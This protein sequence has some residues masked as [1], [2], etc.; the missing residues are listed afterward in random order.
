MME[1]KMRR[2]IIV[3][4]FLLVAGLIFKIAPD[5][6][7]GETY[8][9]NVIR[10]VLDDNEITNS[11]PQKALI[12]N[13]KVMLSRATVDKY[14]DKYL[15]YDEKYN[16]II[17]TTD[18]M[19]SKLTIGENK[20]QINKDIK[21]ISVPAQ[22]IDGNIY[23][24]IEELQDVYGIIVKYNEKVVITNKSI[25]R[26]IITVGND[27][28]VYKFKKKFSRIIDKVKEGE[29][30][31]IYGIKPS[32]WILVRTED[33]NL[34]YV[35]VNKI[36]P[37]DYQVQMPEPEYTGALPKIN[38][39]WEYAENYTPNRTGEA[40]IEGLNVVSPTW[41][42][43]KNTNGDV[44]SKID[45][46]YIN[47]AHDNRYNVWA[48]F[49]NDGIGIEGTSAVITDMKKREKMINQI[50]DFATENEINGINVDFENMKETDIN[51]YSQFIRELSAMLR[52]KGLTVS[53][54][55]TVPD[56][57]PTW[58][59]CY[60]R[61]ELN[62]AVDYI[63]LMAYD[64]NGVSSS[65]A[66]SVASLN[67]VEANIKKMLNLGVEKRKLILGIPFYS[68]IWTIQGDTLSSYTVGMQDQMNYLNMQNKEWL[69]D[70]GQYYVEYTYNNK[71]VKL[72]AEESESIAE[73][74]RLSKEYELAGVA[75]WRRGY[76]TE[77]IWKVIKDN[78]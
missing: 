6:I 38:L 10:V 69:E 64:Q 59:L 26:A 3:I 63:I 39:V 75:A 12:I 34:G 45:K 43:L 13:G 62:D 41:F 33:G 5:Y 58:S 37:T 35:D 73:K 30:I 66:G 18:T 49:K 4:L 11:M 65:K 20:I 54:D 78:M 8:E 32:G 17:T 1:E 60:N 74:V 51:E 2:I 19:V 15:Y 7:I 53:V 57:S 46:S 72:W 70:E 29:K 36:N 52:N 67:W 27:I 14:F 56:G 48:A 9:K 31:D 16:T 47:W 25:E 76:E 68:R 61:K 28:T 71:I 50:A 55:V 42:Y 77:N 40:K 24:P 21:D 44:T 22:V 23:I